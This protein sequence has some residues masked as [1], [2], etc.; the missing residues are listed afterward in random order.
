MELHFRKRFLPILTAV[1]IVTGCQTDSFL[2]D[3]KHVRLGMDK[4][5]LVETLGDAQRKERRNGKEWWFYT[6]YENKQKYERLVVFENNKV[7]YAGRVAT[8]KDFKDADLVDKQNELTNKALESQ[9]ERDR[10]NIIPTQESPP[11]APDDSTASP[12]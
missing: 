12:P 10:V 2:K 9:N 1:F 6:V 4:F 8:P 5:D 3:F 7:I 11:S